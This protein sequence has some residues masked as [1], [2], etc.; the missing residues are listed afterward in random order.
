MPDLMI[1]FLSLLAIKLMGSAAH[2]KA[3]Q[4]KPRK[5]KEVTAGRNGMAG[6]SASFA[7]CRHFCAGS[8]VGV[9]VVLNKDT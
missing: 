8:L 7:Q 9:I 4:A 3:D 2:M 1:H 6:E 5:G